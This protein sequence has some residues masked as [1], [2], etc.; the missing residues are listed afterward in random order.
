MIEEARRQL[1]EASARDPDAVFAAGVAAINAGIEDEALPLLERAVRA[2]PHYARLWQALGL[3]CRG[4]EELAPAIRALERA[5]LL[6][7]NDGLI[8][9]GLARTAMEAGLP[10]VALFDRARRVAPKDLSIV[11]SRTAALFLEGR[12]A[13]AFE[14][15][16]IELARNSRWFEGQ[17]ALARLR[18]MTG[19]RDGFTAGYE[20]ALARGPADAELWG[21]LIR[22][23]IDA[24][25]YDDAVEAI[26]RARRGTG[27]LAVFDA[28]EA[29]AKAETGDT[30]AADRLFARLGP[31]R[32]LTLVVRVVRHYLRSG[33]PR[34]AAALAE[35]FLDDDPTGQLW[36]YLSAAWRLTGDTRWEW[37][38]GDP[39]LVGVYDIGDSVGD[40]EGLAE[41][42]RGLHLA[43]HQPLEQSVR[44]GTQTDGPL[45]ARIDPE[46]RALRRAIVEAVEAHVALLPPPRPGHPLLGMPRRG[47][48]RFSGSWSVRLTGGG[49]HANHIHPAGWLSSAFYVAL[50]P[51]EERGPEPAGWL[52]LGEATEL[53]L[54]L[55]P[56]RTV[57]PKPGRLVLFPSTMWHGTRPFDA[58]ERLTVAFD[59]APPRG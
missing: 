53:G 2:N 9:H 41:R 49:R 20:A 36:P 46:I 24:E 21:E 58:G 19:G 59:V 42:L 35:S 44:G 1:R 50:P 14:S 32:H 30:A 7:P 13:E 47:R 16:E 40:L 15:L 5:A 25:L 57:E 54:D 18:W 3:A 17:S 22:T 10:S 45:F 23:L 29:I 4:L 52:T 12:L 55:P 39:A 43:T 34:D 56:L 37:L 8:A 26:D 33:R 48:V 31:P 51:V 6:A 27:G 38:E 11:L 28:M